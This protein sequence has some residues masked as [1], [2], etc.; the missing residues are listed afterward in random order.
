MTFVSHGYMGAASYAQLN[1]VL[2]LNC[3]VAAPTVGAILGSA[4]DT[5]DWIAWKLGLTKKRWALYAI[6]HHNRIAVL[7]ECLLVA[8]GLHVLFDRLIHSPVIP[9]PFE[10]VKEFDVEVW[11]IFGI[12]LKRRDI[13]WLMGE[14]LVLSL[15]TH[16]WVAL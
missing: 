7:I 8:P 11:R 14:A 1:R 4:P 3:D 6:L 16:I 13:F 2:G 9:H 5:F 15:A 12:V 10:G